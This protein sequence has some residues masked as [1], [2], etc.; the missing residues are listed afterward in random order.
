MAL[1]VVS[2]VSLRVSDRDRSEQFYNPIL[3][4]LGYR[5]V[6]RNTEFTQWWSPQAGAF[7]LSFTAEA[8]HPAPAKAL[9]LHH[10]AFH[11]ESRQQVDTLYE[12]LQALKAHV[13]SAPMEASAQA[14]YYAV[15]F[16]DPD[17]IQLELVF[18]EE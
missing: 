1:G 3:Q 10:L 11:A 12:L 9:G 13:L 16:A 8:A 5:P 18:V 15:L 2:H 7:T 4:F 14:G 17:G 6:A